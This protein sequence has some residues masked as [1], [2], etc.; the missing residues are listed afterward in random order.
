ML[1]FFLTIEAVVAYKTESITSGISLD[2]AVINIKICMCL[3]FKMIA[4][5]N[6]FIGIYRTK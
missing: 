6:I 3:C 5:V 2:Y 4:S 1:V